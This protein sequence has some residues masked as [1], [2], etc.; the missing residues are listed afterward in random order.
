[1][2]DAEPDDGLLDVLI[3]EKVNV[4]QV[5]GI[6]GKYQAG[7]YRELPNLIRHLQTRDIRIETPKDA[8]VQFDGES[9][10]AKDITFRISDKKLRFFYPKGL[11]Y[12]AAEPAV[13]G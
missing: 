7:Q 8:V 2:P 1:M 13:I 10:V 5:A 9:L 6:I 11:S 4:L 12:K 3:V